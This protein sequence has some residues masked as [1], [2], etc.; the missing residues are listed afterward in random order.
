MSQ[1]IQRPPKLEHAYG[2]VFAEFNFMKKKLPLIC[3]TLKHHRELRHQL[4]NPIILPIILT[5]YLFEKSKNRNYFSL[6]LHLRSQPTLF[7]LAL[8]LCHLYVI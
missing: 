1:T 3:F 2:F 4:F 8:N 7:F 5:A 6:R